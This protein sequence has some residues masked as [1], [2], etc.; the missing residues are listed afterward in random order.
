MADN[1]RDFYR[2]QDR[3]RMAW[4]FA[5]IEPTSETASA[6]LTLNR[7][8]EEELLELNEDAPKQHESS[9]C[10]IARLSCWLVER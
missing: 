4:R 2:I 7:E 5:D 8:L 10:S 1:Q 3:L 9:H 6:L